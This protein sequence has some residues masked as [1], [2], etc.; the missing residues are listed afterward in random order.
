MGQKIYLIQ[1]N[2]KLAPMEE[3]PYASEELLQSLLEDYPDLLAGDQMSEEN[4]RRW[5][6][7]S[8]EYG[9]PD[10]DDAGNRWSI[11]HLFVDQDSVPT[12]IE[13][14]RSTD[15][16]IRREVVGQMLDYAANAVA[17]WP[18]ERLRADFES[19]VT[20]KGLDPDGV[21]SE[22]LGLPAPDNEAV[23]AF[24]RQDG[25]NLDAGKLRLVFVAD[26]IPLELKRIVEFLNG[27]MRAE[28]LAVEIKQ[29]V[30]Q[31]HRTLVPKVVGQTAIAAMKS[32]PSDRRVSPWTVEEVLERL[33]AG[34]HP[35]DLPQIQAI[36]DWAK[37]E[38]AQIEGGYGPK[39]ASLLIDVADPATNE[40][41]RPFQIYDAHNRATLYLQLRHM[42]PRLSTPA[43]AAALRKRVRQATGIKIDESKT[44]P[45]IRTDY[46]RDPAKL[47]GL[48]DAMK[49]VVSVIRGKDDLQ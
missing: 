15:T 23:D 45:G 44:Y 18:V 4:P 9:V 30:G 29:F 31:G 42:G 36:I 49:W 27:Q 11:D 20:Q 21:V 40:V 6:L 22:F 47:A 32:A 8:R 16:R 2:Q 38:D 28:V 24:W 26:Q 34:N 43:G 41:H 39:S 25:V 10:A 19:R 46:F 1:P 7:I 5:L 12:L 48:L 33:K 3:Q 35:E 17:F 14:K 13:V 37:R